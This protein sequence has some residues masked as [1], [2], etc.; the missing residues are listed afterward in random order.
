MGEG[1]GGARAEA[2]VDPAPDRGCPQMSGVQSP[3]QGLSSDEWGAEQAWALPQTIAHERGAEHL[4][5]P[6]GF[7]PR[8]LG[9]LS[10]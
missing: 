8:P 7:A 6:H 10:R 2:G 4:P 9:L 5:L 3:R 1:G